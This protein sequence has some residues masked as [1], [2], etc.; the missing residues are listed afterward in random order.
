MFEEDAVRRRNKLIWVSDG[1][2]IVVSL[3]LNGVDV[4]NLFS[5]HKLFDADGVSFGWESWNRGAIEVSEDLFWA[6]AE[7]QVSG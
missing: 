3:L 6:R 2:F 1:P 7:Q 5:W 4:S